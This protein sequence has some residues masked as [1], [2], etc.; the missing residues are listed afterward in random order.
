L[1]AARRAVATLAAVALAALTAVNVT[2]PPGPDKRPPEHAQ[3][4]RTQTSDDLLSLAANHG[5]TQVRHYYGTYLLLGRVTGGGVLTA[6]EDLFGQDHTWL[7]F[8]GLEVQESDGDH[9][10]AAEEL[11]AFLALPHTRG[12]YAEEQLSTD[13]PVT[14]WVVVHPDDDDD[15]QAWGVVTADDVVVIASE[16]LLRQTGVGWD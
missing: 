3:A 10:I 13:P 11:D 8:S 16:R 6:P 14:E 5:N 7:A 9:R 2:A 4:F 12:Q 1:Q 15:E